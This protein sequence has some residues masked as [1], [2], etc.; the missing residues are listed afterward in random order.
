M[1]PHPSFRYA[2]IHLLPQEKA[3]FSAA[4]APLSALCATF[5][6]KRGNLPAGEGFLFGD[7][8][9]SRRG[10]LAQG[11]YKAA[12]TFVFT[13]FCSPN[14]IFDEQKKH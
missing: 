14:T 3:F 5:P 4:D 8:K 10:N 6:A 7:G 2:Q 1:T 12:K 13:P 9:A 11:Y